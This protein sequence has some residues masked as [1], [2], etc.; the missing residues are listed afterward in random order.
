MKLEKLSATA[1]LVSSVAIVVT[2]L[3]LTVEVRQ[4]TDALHAQSRQSVLTSA[5]T[6][7]FVALDH[8]EITKSM[9]K[10]GPLTAEE[11]IQIDAFLTAALRV[12]EFSWLQ[13]RSG[14]IDE[15][16][17]NTELAV[18]RS[19]LSSARSRLWWD[20]LGRSYVSAEFSEFL[21]GVISDL[22]SGNDDWET[23]AT[24]SDP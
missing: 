22:P 23:I 14:L 5:Q 19:L 7:L 9:I 1:E 10:P 20:K 17:W 3:Y 11:N 24:W 8:P 21:D 15:A 4:N 16:Q 2:L 6:E 18:M 12:R 13:F